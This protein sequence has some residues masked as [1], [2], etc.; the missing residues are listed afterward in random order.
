[1]HKKRLN[2]YSNMYYKYFLI[3]LTSI[4]FICSCKTKQLAIDGTKAYESKQYA[5]ATELLPKELS[6]LKTTEER[7]NKTLMTARAFDAYNNPSDAVKWYEKTLEIKETGD[8]LFEY[9]LELKKN[10]DYKK[11]I[12]VFEKILAE[13]KDLEPEC[14]RHIE[15]SQ[16]AQVWM[17]EAQSAKAINLETINSSA[18]DYGSYK[19]KNG[20]IIFTSDRTD[21]TGDKK[22]TWTQEKFGDLYSTSKN[23]NNYEAP[24][25]FSNLNTNYYE[26]T[27]CFTKD[28]NTMYFTRC[29]SDGIKND[30]CS[31]YKSTFDGVNWS[32]AEKINLLHD[33]CNVGQPFLSPDNKILYFVSD[34]KGGFGGKD[35]YS[36]PITADGMGEVSNLGTYVNTES[37]E[38]FPTLDNTNTLYFSSTGHSG[39]GGLDIFRATKEKNIWKNIDNMRYPINS[40]ADDF[41]LFM[42]KTKPSS[43]ADTLLKSGYLSSSRKNGKGFDDIYSYELYLKNNFVLVVK[44]FAKKYENPEDSKSKVIDI[45]LLKDAKVEL[46]SELVKSLL[47]DEKGLAKFDLEKEKNYS[48]VATKNGYLKNTATT[49]TIGKIDA[50]RNEIVIQVDIELEKIFSNKDIEISNIYYDLDKATL[51][52]ESFPALDTLLAIFKQNPDITVEIGSHTDS[53]GSDAYNLK[54]SQARA[55]SVVDYLIT[56]GIET[57]RLI[58]KGYG[59]TK[60]LN[61]CGNDVKCTEEE[62][63]RNRRT[64]FRVVGQKISIE[65]KE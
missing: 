52:P 51:R 23:G 43:V 3:L 17:N 63:Q 31:I 4:I 56:K 27:P 45:E 64:T 58:A 9:A 59:E 37:D 55:Q 36:V 32:E 19:L 6:A 20:T 47:T 1:M 10:E 46:S 29:G 21:A 54:L 62:H 15:I 39:L 34:E 8:I 60:L 18:S 16:L 2:L 50:S 5:L 48:I 7:Y 42:E 65:S 35:I 28:N 61:N 12:S 38:M 33:S 13:D 49:S 14:R 11:A 44:V 40:G 25:K 53:R 24:I 26:G 22:Y 30:Y 41:Y 57:E